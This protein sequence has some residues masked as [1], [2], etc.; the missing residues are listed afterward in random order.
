MIKIEI[1]QYFYRDITIFPFFLKAMS[2]IKYKKN[3]YKSLMLIISLSLT[4]FLFFGKQ[5][6]NYQL[7]S[8][9]SD[10][11]F[12]NFCHFEGKLFTGTDH[13]LLLF[14]NPSEIIAYDT[15]RKGY[16]YNSD[17][18]IIASEIFLNGSATPEYSNFLPKEFKSNSIIGTSYKDFVLI[19]A[20]GQLFI[21][22]K[23]IQ[24][25]LSNL[26]IRTL[27]KNY[28]GSYSGIFYK[29]KL[30]TN[31]KYT[32]GYIREF[33][34]E[35][36]I[37]YDGIYRINKNNTI[38][39]YNL[40]G[41]KFSNLNLGRATDIYKVSTNQYLIFSST[42]LFVTNLINYA[43][44]ILPTK[45]AN[46]PRFINTMDRHGTPTYLFFCL[47]NSLYRYTISSG[48][49]NKIFELDSNLGNIEDCYF[50]PYSTG[51]IFVITKDKL[52]QANISINGSYSFNILNEDLHSN[53]HIIKYNDNLL[54]TSNSGLSSFNL[55]T[56]KLTKNI[57]K[58]EFNKRAVYQSGDILYLGTINGYYKLNNVQINQLINSAT[59]DKKNV[60]K[61]SDDLLYYFLYSLIIFCIIL[62]ISNF[63]FIKKQ[64]KKTQINL[65]VSKQEI[66]QF[67]ENN[68]D[69]VTIHNI[70]E[71]FNIS[72]IQLTQVLEN[73]KPGKFIREKR[74]EIVDKMKKQKKD[75]DTIS[76]ASGFSVSYLKKLKTNNQ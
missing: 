28:I 3:Q 62:L 6:D 70:C 8:V 67:I 5:Q 71:N 34:D 12:Y 55:I 11:H 66:V 42:G 9:I 68:I 63:Y 75:I 53:H 10:I 19:I 49:C 24:T 72:S 46:E 4:P 31:L 65:I 43:E 58:D 64:R 21:Y 32:N 76:K 25:Y 52:L 29:G 51:K 1:F 59:Y 18:E 73:E 54:I 27:S 36:F 47:N 57:I 20:K 23:K 22:K 60:F 16:I 41:K 56:K 61:N 35:S 44:T 39:Y 45:K 37:C 17:N 14:K 2:K 48:K 30:F 13:G 74:I 69:N 26:S 38:N 33:Q 40:G 50:D 15:D 7:K